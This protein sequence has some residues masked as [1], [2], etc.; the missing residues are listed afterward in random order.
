MSTPSA[1][2]LTARVKLPVPR[3]RAYALLSEAKH[4][5]MW[6]CEHADVDFDVP[7]YN[8][9]GIHTPGAPRAEDMVTRL[10]TWG[11][12]RGLRFSWLIRGRHTDVE[13]FLEDD[14]ATACLLTVRHANLPDR[15]EHE[16]AL[17][18]FWY[19]ALENLRLYAT[20]GKPQFMPDYRPKAGSVIELEIEIDG[21]PAAV[22]DKF[23][24]MEQFNR[25]YG[26]NATMDARVGGK[27]DYGWGPG[28]GPQ[29]ILELE[30][31]RKL[32]YSWCYDNEPATVVTW[33]LAESGGRTRLTI[34]HSGF[35]ADY[36]SEGYR[37][38][39]FSFLAIIKGMVELGDE[40][41]MVSI[42]GL[43]HGDA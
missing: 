14:G 34:T 17:H 23:A 18:D 33:S 26:A 42:E 7:R 25:Y 41:E 28:K 21:T 10:Y 12:L 3:A 29:Q 2:S 31:E 20:T 15:A 27:V 22:W 16:A 24:N 30:P 4:L 38:G 37:A 35:A 1:K 39:W 11:G 36:D 9:W 5:T 32:S 40:W 19:I 43:K 6:F 13:Y 8:F